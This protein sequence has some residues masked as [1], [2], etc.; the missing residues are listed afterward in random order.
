MVY[1]FY[2][3]DIVILYACLE[4]LEYLFPEPC[5]ILWLAV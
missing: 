2:G 5:I 1:C 4:N 3:D